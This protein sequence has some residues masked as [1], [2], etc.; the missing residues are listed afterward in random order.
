MTT[1]K[2][3]HEILRE[4]IKCVD[5]VPEYS[6]FLTVSELYK[7]TRELASKYSDQVEVIEAG[8]AR[9][10]DP[11]LAI[12]VGEGRRTVLAFGFPHPNEPIGS[13]VL[14]YLSRYLVENPEL[15]KLTN[16]TWIIVKV[17][18]VYGAKLNE[19]W[20]K[21]PFSIRKYI[22]NYYRPPAYL[23]V[24]WTFPIEYK[25]LKWDKPT[26]ETRAIM[27]LIDDYRP[28]F[29]FSLH[30]SSFTGVYFY[31]S[32]P[33]PQLY[34]YLHEAAKRHNIPLH[35]GEPEVPYAK[36]LTDAVFKLISTKEYY[37]FLEQQ[38]G[39]V[40]IEKIKHGGSSMDYAERLGKDFLEVVIEVPYIVDDRIFNTTPIGV[41]RRDIILLTISKLREELSELKRYFEKVESKS[42]RENPFTE[43]LRYFLEI[44]EV[45]LEAEEKW[46]KTAKETLRSATVAETFDEYVSN[47]LWSRMLRWGLLYRAIKYE[48]ERGTKELEQ[49]LK[50]IDQKLEQ[51]TKI[52]EY[53]AQYRTLP[54]KSLVQTQL[55]T[56][57]MT[58][59][60]AQ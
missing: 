29:I 24:E 60:I 30:N 37:D 25:E 7:S 19:G 17:A 48:V 26:P 58:V 3:K 32:K 47:Y 21:G 56:I 12:K 10:G 35:L 11:V 8:V 23:Q 13:L 9:T 16:T 36:K 28:D 34:P 2:V 42:S 51:M 59:A 49:L 5:S 31:L 27:K 50:E 38:L 40:P 22:R 41:P 18:D 54:I 46:A 4:V 33:V 1:T 39:K 6:D 43:A 14:E 52:F 15:W 44:L 20:F 45:N 57:L 55:Y 53:Y